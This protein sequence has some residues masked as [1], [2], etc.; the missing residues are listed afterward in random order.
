MR[1]MHKAS[2]SVTIDFSTVYANAPSGTAIGL[3][4]PSEAAPLPAVT[5][6]DMHVAGTVGWMMTNG[7]ATV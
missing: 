1:F 3:Q 6:V 2:L 5:S 7:L 4:I